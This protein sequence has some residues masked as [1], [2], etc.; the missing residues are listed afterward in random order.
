[1]NAHGLCLASDGAGHAGEICSAA[2]DGINVI[3]ALALSMMAA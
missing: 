2:I 3:E 1:M